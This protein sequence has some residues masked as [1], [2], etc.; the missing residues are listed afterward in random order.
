MNKFPWSVLGIDP[1]G[2]RQ[3]IMKA[4]AAQLKVTRPDEDPVG[5]QKLREARE[6]ALKLSEKISE[7]AEIP[8]IVPE[9]ETVADAD[10]IDVDSTAKQIQSPSVQ[11]SGRFVATAKQNT[12]VHYDPQSQTIGEEPDALKLLAGIDNRVSAEQVEKQWAAVFDALENARFDIQ[13]QKRRI[14]LQ[15]LL[16]NI[17]DKVGKIPV[18]ANWDPGLISAKSSSLGPYFNILRDLENRNRFLTEDRRV[19]ET[20]SRDDAIDLLSLL[21]VTVGRKSDPTQKTAGRKAIQDVPMDI[22]EAG[23]ASNRPLAAYY[24]ESLRRGSYKRGFTLLALIFPLPFALYYRL[25]RFSALLGAATLAVIVSCEL[26]RSGG[27]ASAFGFGYL[28][29]LIQALSLARHWRQLKIKRLFEFAS[30]LKKKGLDP[31]LLKR[32]LLAWGRPDK[33]SAIFIGGALQLVLVFE[34][35]ISIGSIGDLLHSF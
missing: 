35:L 10:G 31:I 22:L 30:A 33:L 2:D 18:V 4:Y 23:L 28:I 27:E 16:Q 25:Y 8:A 17:R 14:V 13:F 21:T 32:R 24:A 7:P 12:Y 15:R 11:V 5:F 20:L 29:Y 19:F 6:L 26:I 1:T 34:I 9:K 3:N